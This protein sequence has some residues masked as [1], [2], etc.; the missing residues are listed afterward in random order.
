MASSS[1]LNPNTPLAFLP[2]TIANQTQ[3]ADYVF[4]GALSVSAS[5]P[6]PTGMRLTSPTSRHLFG[7]GAPLCRKSIQSSAK[8]GSV[9]QTLLMSYHGQQNDISDLPITYGRVVL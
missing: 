9:Y 2:P 5:F 6:T 3:I 4:V 1:I 7:T 8:V